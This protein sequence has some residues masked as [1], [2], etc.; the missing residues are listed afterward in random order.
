MILRRFRKNEDGV[1][2]IEFALIAPIII[3]AIMA[4]AD[5][6]LASYD[7]MKLTSGVRNG[8]HYL[9]MIGDDPAV[10]Q[11]IV[12]RSSGLGEKIVGVEVNQYCACSGSE[13]VPTEC[14]VECSDGNMT[15][16]YTRIT[17]AAYSKQLLKSW[18][19]L[20]DVEVRKR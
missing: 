1:V 9:M 11:E 16:V 18:K 5:L 4:M 8:A 15:N 10:V 13:G 7:R 3:F 20:S 14:A 19:L 17:A 6:G 2:A 12:I